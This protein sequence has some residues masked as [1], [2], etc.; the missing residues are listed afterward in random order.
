MLFVCAEC[1]ALLPAHLGHHRFS[2]ELRLG[3]SPF[4]SLVRRDVKV[5]G[6]RL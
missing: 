5:G 3:L 4:E 1:L 2:F 6:L